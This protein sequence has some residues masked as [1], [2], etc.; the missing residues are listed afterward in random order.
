MNKIIFGCFAVLLLAGCITVEVTGVKSDGC[1]WVSPLYMQKPSITA[2]RNA[3]KEHPEVR[4]DREKIVAHNKNYQANCPPD[5]P[6]E[7]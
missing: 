3:Q 6:K 5:E 1:S 7:K 2:L 4:I